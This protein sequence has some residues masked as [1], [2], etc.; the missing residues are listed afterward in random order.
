MFGFPRPRHRP[1]PPDRVTLAIEGREVTVAVKVSARAVRFTLRLSTG[2]GEP[3]LTLP[4]RASFGD[5]LAFLDRHR[6]WLGERLARRPRSVAF[7]PG[8]VLPL[9]GRP[10]RVVHRPERRGTVWVEEAGDEALLVVAGGIDHLP[11]RIRDHLIRAARGDL[12]AAV[13]RH[14]ERLGVKIGRI[15]IK[16]TRSRWGSCTAAG[17][18]SFSWRVILAPPEVLD[19]LAAHEVAHLREMNHSVRF[20]RLVRATC[21]TMDQ[22][23]RWLKVH[24]AALHGYGGAEEGAGHDASAFAGE[25]FA[26]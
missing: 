10:H 18:L 25:P 7:R 24:G 15:R 21:P 6:G 17:D 16:D 4:A 19:Y 11:R 2:T 1:S 14:A 12:A 9:R 8:A 13:A 3:V 5:A 22:G 20:W 23:R 26:C